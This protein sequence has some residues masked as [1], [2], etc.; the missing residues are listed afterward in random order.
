M[1]A[2]APER[3]RS[4]RKARERI[5]RAA[6]DIAATPDRWRSIVNQLRPALGRPPLAA[7]VLAPGTYDF[8]RAHHGATSLAYPIK[9]MQAL[10]GGGMNTVLRTNE[11]FT[12][13]EI[14][15][16]RHLPAESA[17]EA[18][19]R[20]ERDTLVRE[21]LSTLPRHPIIPR[22]WTTGVVQGEACDV[23]DFAP[24]MSLARYVAQRGLTYGIL[25]D[26]SLHAARGIGYL[27]RNGLIH[28]D[29]K[30]EN[31]CVETRITASHEPT[32]HVS[33][34]DFD[35]VSTAAEQI[36][37]YSL[38]NSLD[39]TLPYMPPENFRQDIPEDPE[40]ARKMVFS[41]DVFALGLTMARTSIGAFPR[42]FYTQVASLLE[43]KV[44]GDEIELEFPPQMPAKMQ[45]LI[46]AMCSSVWQERPAIA[47]VIRA[48]RSLRDPASA[49][50]RRIVLSSP[51]EDIVTKVVPAQEV[52]TVGPYNL[53]NR[54]YLPRPTKDGHDLPLAEFS[55]PFGRKLIGVPFAFDKKEDEAAFYKEREVLLLDLNAVRLKHPELFPGSFRDLVREQRDGRFLVWM[56]RPLL[57]GPKDLLQFLKEDRPN[58][59]I[60]ER[61]AILRRVAEALAVLEEA[62]YTLPKLTPELVFFVA[63]PAETSSTTSQALTRPIKRL[64]D[65]PARGEQRYRQELMGTSSA[66]K[67]NPAEK[68]KRL[69][70]DLLDIAEQIGVFADIGLAERNFLLQI[71]GVDTWRERVSIL[72]WVEM[73][74]V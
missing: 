60:K 41:K 72:V 36:R 73:Q 57:E 40:D 42:S 22:F 11:Y 47:T 51:A 61:I 13:R 66:R 58:A 31:F 69:V 30:P 52:E 1:A 44:A 15:V 5:D 26:F 48:L 12:G 28:G 24:G 37:Q 55:D 10:D 43:K 32:V 63:A 17:V 35:I 14:T 33:L 56:L 8:I 39:G 74:T 50:D 23:F 68:G 16:R 65:V 29:V 64:F 54:S 71:A 6:I 20:L 34:I 53:L 25:L 3:I 9:R 45:V 49:E 18:A 70:T 7:E 62:G 4:P 46:R 21:R 59:P 2:A 38:G 67:V 27:H 19:A